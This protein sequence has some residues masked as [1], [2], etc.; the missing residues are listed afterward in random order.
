[1]V[2]DVAARLPVSPGAL[3]AST[4]FTDTPATAR[5]QPWST[6]CGG[7]IKTGNRT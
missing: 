7:P 2:A 4:A 1:M 6:G 5:S 3:P